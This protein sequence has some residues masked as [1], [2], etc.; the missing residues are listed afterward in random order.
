MTRAKFASEQQPV[1]TVIDGNKVYVF[2]CLNG[3]HGTDVQDGYDGEQVTEEYIEYDYNEFTIDKDTIDLDD[4]INN[5]EKYLNYVP[6][7]QIND[8]TLDEYKMYRQEENKMALA[9]F[10]RTQTVTFNGKEYGVS[11]EDQNEM[12]LNLTQY[13]VLTASGQDVSLEWHSKKEKCEKFTQEEF[14]KLIAMIKAFVYP[15]YQKMQDIKTN[16]FNSKNKF[17]LSVI[18][19]KYE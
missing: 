3:I 14:I 1:K 4:I 5:P 16:I 12:A 2:I 15:Y 9:D 10:L 13:Q 7:S 18:E 17:E 8:M 11:E 19:I 6:D